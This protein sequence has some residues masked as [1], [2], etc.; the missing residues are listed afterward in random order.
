M[1]AALKA[2]SEK[3]KLYKNIDL[4]RQSIVA[5]LQESETSRAFLK[6]SILETDAKHR[7]ELT[8]MEEA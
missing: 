1:R 2:L 4:E 6:N 5:V 7:E 3:L 8:K